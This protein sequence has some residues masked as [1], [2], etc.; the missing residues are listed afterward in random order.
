MERENLIPAVQLAWA[1]AHAVVGF[2]M[3][4]EGGF[5]ADERF[6]ANGNVVA[7]ALAVVLAGVGGVVAD[8]GNDDAA[9]AVVIDIVAVA[10]MVFAG[11]AEPKYW[12]VHCSC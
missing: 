10:A 1:A 2:A 5:V 9:A 6:V 11:V 12:P 3:T 7:V 8:V 4:V